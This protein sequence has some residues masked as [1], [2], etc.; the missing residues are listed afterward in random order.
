MLFEEFYVEHGIDHEVIAPYTPRHNGIKE[1]RNKTMLKMDRCMLKQKNLQKSL[2]VE[3]V[4]MVVKLAGR[5][6]NSYEFM[7]LGS[8][9]E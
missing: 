2:W 5:L 8:K 3:A 9:N 1:I 6:V 7:I 4:T